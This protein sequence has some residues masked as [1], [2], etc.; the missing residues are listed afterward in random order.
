MQIAGVLMA[1]LHGVPFKSQRAKDANG[2]EVGGKGNVVDGMTN[3]TTPRFFAHVLLNQT[4]W[5]SLQSNQRAG[6][7]IQTRVLLNSFEKILFYECSSK[8]IWS[9]VFSTLTASILKQHIQRNHIKL[10][11]FLQCLQHIK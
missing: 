11:N 4:P 7:V 10:L 9:C 2:S 8:I 1:Y 5:S 3:N 6:H